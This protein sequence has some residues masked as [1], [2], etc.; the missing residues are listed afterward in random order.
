MDALLIALGL[1]GRRQPGHIHPVTML[2][3]PLPRDRAIG[4]AKY[5]LEQSDAIA[6]G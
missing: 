2:P 1:N 4:R 3:P 6:V 5:S